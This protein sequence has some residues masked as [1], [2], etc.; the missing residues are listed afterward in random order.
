MIHCLDFCL[1]WFLPL[2]LLQW[3]NLLESRYF[4][5]WYV[6]LASSP[7]QWCS[8]EELQGSPA[9]EQA[10]RKG[11]AWKMRAVITDLCCWT[12]LPY[13]GI[14][15][16]FSIS[17]KSFPFLHIL[18][19]TKFIIT[20]WSKA[21]ING[22]QWLQALP[23]LKLRH[24]NHELVYR[25]HT[26]S[27]SRAIGETVSIWAVSLVLNFMQSCSLYFVQVTLK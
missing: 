13:F 18:G 20:R 27:V 5:L 22:T 7:S 26:R 21:N 11:E 9:V 14:G 8:C 3:N 16:S 25:Y 19:R 23:I 24:R 6:R 2:E 1:V 17:C 12:V 15:L 10:S 4:W